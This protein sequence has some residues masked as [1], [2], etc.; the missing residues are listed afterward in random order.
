MEMKPAGEGV[1]HISLFRG[2]LLMHEPFS[3][4][5][6]QKR[7]NV[8]TGPSS[9]ISDCCNECTVKRRKIPEGLQCSFHSFYWI[10]FWATS[11]WKSQARCQVCGST[12]NPHPCWF[13]WD[14]HKW[15]STLLV[16]PIPLELYNRF[17]HVSGSE[18][19][20]LCGRNWLLVPWKLPASPAM[21]Q[22]HV[23]IQDTNTSVRCC[24]WSLQSTFH[25]QR[26]ADLTSSC[27]SGCFRPRWAQ[28]EAAERVCRTSPRPATIRTTVKAP[29]LS[30]LNPP[31]IA[32]WFK[33]AFIIHTTVVF[34]AEGNRFN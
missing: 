1:T 26:G 12:G 27:S 8:I 34:G 13:L 4:V 30:C 20:C 18:K 22:L 7:Y 10:Y 11:V 32:A 15:Y 21:A 24:V 5:R 29:E 23:S 17:Q 28:D 3:E 9:R 31:A 19:C 33:I 16:L 25:H 6:V 14:F 2:T